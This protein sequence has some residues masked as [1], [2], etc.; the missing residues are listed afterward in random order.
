VH[1]GV[2]LQPTYRIRNGRP[3][4]QLYGR[5]E[6]GR[7]F[8]VEDDRFSPYFFVRECDRHHLQKDANVSI[9]ETELSTLAGEPVCRITTSLPSAI[10]DLRNRLARTG[11]ASYEADLRFAYRYLMDHAL[12]DSIGIE[13]SIESEGR[14]G[15]GGPGAGLVRFINPDLVPSEAEITLSHLR[16]TPPPWWGAALKKCIWSL[17]RRLRAPRSISMK[18]TS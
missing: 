2:I 16:S 5:L 11:V 18:P 15:D 14:S 13:G 10:R 8:L 7:A 6:S 12:R 9:R 1:H 3:V 4:V 17:P